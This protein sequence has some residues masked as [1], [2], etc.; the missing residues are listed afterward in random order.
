MQRIYIVQHPDNPML[1]YTHARGDQWSTDI[2]R[3]H[4]FRAWRFAELAIVRHL[5]GR[6]LVLVRIRPNES[7]KEMRARMRREEAM[8]I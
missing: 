2:D 4:G 5:N 7:G 1:F 6:G 3:A 8:E